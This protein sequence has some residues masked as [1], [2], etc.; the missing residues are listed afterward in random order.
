MARLTRTQASHLDTV[1]EALTASY[2]G[3]V[4][5]TRKAREIM[6]QNS[7]LPHI[8]GNSGIFLNAHGVLMAGCRAQRRDILTAKAAWP[9]E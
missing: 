6:W 2:N 9:G 4:V 8:R 3:D 7:A 5:F 1:A